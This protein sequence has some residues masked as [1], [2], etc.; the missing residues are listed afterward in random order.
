MNID[1]INLKARLQNFDE[2]VSISSDLMLMSLNNK[3]NPDHPDLSYFQHPYRMETTAITL[4]VEGGVTFNL[5][6]KKYEITAPCMII[7]SPGQILQHVR[8]E[9]NHNV[10]HIHFSRGFIDNMTK[11]FKDFFLFNHQIKNHAAIPLTPDD[12]K[13]LLNFYDKARRVVL[14]VENPYRMEMVF[15]LSAILF[16][17]I[18]SRIKTEPDESFKSSRALLV[19]NFL[20]MVQDNH[21]EHRDLSF[22]AEK[23]HLTPKYLTTVIKRESGVSA[24]DWIE[25]HVILQA[26]ALLKSTDLTIQQISDKLNFSSQVFFGK[27]FKRLAGMSPKEY[28]KV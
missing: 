25:R 1:N 9:K 23:L 15:H 11:Y 13:E 12:L 4:I 27:Y 5:D 28:R 17:D 14:D 6:L 24:S 22:Y 26:Q 7:Y 18:L 19:N 10:R 2:V 16:Y 21:I 8:R 20:N 3:D